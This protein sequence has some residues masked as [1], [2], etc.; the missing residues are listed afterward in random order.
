MGGGRPK[1]VPPAV[2]EPPKARYSTLGPSGKEVLTPRTYTS[3]QLQ[4]LATNMHLWACPGK[5]LAARAN[6]ASQGACLVGATWT[7]AFF[8]GWAAFHGNFLLWAASMPP[9][10]CL[11]PKSWVRPKVCS[12]G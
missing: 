3:N 6:A 10:Q 12:L 11:C 2:P 1:L 8:L 4:K 7:Y 9:C 5:V